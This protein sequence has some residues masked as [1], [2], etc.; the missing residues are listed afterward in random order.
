MCFFI[1]KGNGNLEVVWVV[2]LWCF[3][4]VEEG[5]SLVLKECAF[6]V[7]DCIMWVRDWNGF[8]CDF[9]CF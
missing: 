2:I 1:G 9:I 6:S 8:S 5:Y 4:C 3:G 7:I